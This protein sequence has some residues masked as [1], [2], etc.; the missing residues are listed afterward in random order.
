MFLNKP[1]YLKHTQCVY[2]IYKTDQFIRDIFHEYVCYVQTY[3]C[4]SSISYI[5]WAWWKTTVHIYALYIKWIICD[6]HIITFYQWHIYLLERMFQLNSYLFFMFDVVRKNTN[7]LLGNLLHFI[8][9]K[10]KCFLTFRGWL[11]HIEDVNTCIH[12]S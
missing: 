1:K 4:R 3:M 5:H 6:V 2:Y 8:S 10:K 11:F 12:V 9:L 7:C